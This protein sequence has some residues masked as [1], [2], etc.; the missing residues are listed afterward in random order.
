MKNLFLVQTKVSQD[1]WEIIGGNY[2]VR[3]TSEDEIR[4]MKFGYDFCPEE[5]DRI[6]PVNENLFSDEINIYVIN[7]RISE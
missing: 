6:I 4:N 5:I 3:A 7:E 1:K 2:L